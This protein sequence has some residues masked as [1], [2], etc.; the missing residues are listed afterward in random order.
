MKTYL[1]L[2]T[3]VAGMMIGGNVWAQC[4]SS[5]DCASLG[6]TKSSCPDG[7]GVKCP[8]GNAWFCVD[9]CGI[10][11]KYTCTG[12]GYGTQPASAACNGK[13]TS[14]V[15]ADKYTWSG[16]ACTKCASQYTEKCNGSNETGGADTGCGGYYAKCSCATGYEWD[17]TSKS[18]KMKQAVCAVGTLYYSDNTCSA[19]YTTSKTL[20][21]VVVYSNPSGGGWVMTIKPIQSSIIWGGY[22]T[23]ISSLPDYTSWST[24]AKDFDSCGNTDKI[25][26]Q[27][28]SSKYP[29][30]WAAYNYQP[31]G[32]PTGKRWCLPAAG[33]INSLYNNL[34]TINTA[35]GKAGGTKLVNDNEHIWSSSEYSNYRAWVFCTG[36]GAG[37]GGLSD[38]LRNSYYTVVRPVLAF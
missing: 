6:Y 10:G 11:F 25:R 23:N 2:T 14:C 27:G 4:V 20:L 38:Y 26:A 21:G 36:H 30:A 35:I 34:S 29:A 9:Q 3:A 28:N 5:Q 16:T 19:D 8:F 37:S 32:T 33:V 12:T 13:Y 22:G 24:A 1:Y 15:C 31:S 17:T 7:N 18:C